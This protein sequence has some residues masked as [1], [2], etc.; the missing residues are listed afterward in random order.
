MRMILVVVGLLRRGQVI[1]LD[2]KVSL[3]HHPPTRVEG[4]GEGFG[5]E[6]DEEDLPDEEY[7]SE[8]LDAN[9]DGNRR[10]RFVV[11]GAVHS[12]KRY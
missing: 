4:E 1:Q 9:E 7:D 10:G 6:G 3:S 8:D 11:E 12:I 2:R 5:V